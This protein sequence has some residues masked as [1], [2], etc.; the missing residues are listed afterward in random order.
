[1][2]CQRTSS[3]NAFV[4]LTAAPDSVFGWRETRFQALT[5]REVKRLAVLPRRGR[6]VPVIT[7]SSSAWS[8]SAAR[9]ISLGL[10]LVAAQVARPLSELA[11]S[12][13]GRC[14]LLSV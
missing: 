14:L 13:P 12:T 2:D 9:R 10:A 6:S 11:K 8:A 1:V 5:G 3:E 7:R 4:V